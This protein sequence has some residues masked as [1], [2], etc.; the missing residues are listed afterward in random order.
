MALALCVS[1]VV[2]AGLA[3]ILVGGMSLVRPL[4]LLMIR[5]RRQGLVL[6]GTGLLMIPTGVWFPWPLRKSNGAARIDQWL[7]EYQFVEFHETTVKA[8][9]DAVYAAIRAVRANE[10]A[11]FETLV[12]IRHPPLPWRARPVS[13]LNPDANTPILDVATRSGFVWLDDTPREIVVG[14]I[15]C[16]RGARARSADE[17]KSL[18]R[19][20]V[21][22]AAMNFRIDDAGGGVSRVTTETRVAATDTWSRRHF[23]AY[24]SLIFP[25]SS[26][27]RYGWLDAIRRKAEASAAGSDRT[28][29]PP[30]A[31]SR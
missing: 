17:F 5:R 2:Y 9:P 18:T 6:L 24:W 7:P 22:R 23:G 1:L 12:W 30:A 14:T 10:I 31:P 27:I 29:P 19:A 8:R 11:L 4:R 3:A 26:L 20:G 21:A 28:A 16:C 15:V 25:G 13:I